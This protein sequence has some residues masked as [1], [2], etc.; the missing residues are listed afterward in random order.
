MGYIVFEPGMRV[1]EVGRADLVS[2]TDSQKAVEYALAAEFFGMACV[3]LES[4]SGA[5]KPLPSGTIRAVR[6][7]L[8][9]PVIVGGGITTAASARKVVEAGADVIVTG[10]VAERQG[11]T[12]LAEI[13]GAVRKSGA[14][15]K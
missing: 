10:T 7:M 8:S 1:G 6:N 15:G 12:V 5:P 9:I 2:R 11:E 13:I 14:P 3:Y 4:G